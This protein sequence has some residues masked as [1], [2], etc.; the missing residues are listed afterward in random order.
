MGKRSAA[1]AVILALAFNLSA[2]A[3]SP[4][5]QPEV[6]KQDLE[7]SPVPADTLVVP[8]GFQMVD[9][10]VYVPCSRYTDSLAGRNIFHIMPYGVR[11]T[12]SPELYSASKKYIEENEQNALESEGYRIRIYFDNRQDA[13][14]ASERA[15]K[16]FEKLFPAY[17]TYRSYIYPNFK[18][19]VG[20]FRSKTDAQIALKEISR[21]FPSAFIVKERM[22]FPQI[23]LTERYTVDTISISVPLK[24]TIEVDDKWLSKD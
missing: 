4:E 22:K 18:V 23:S 6:V 19:T 5:T 24:D 2:K 14:E 21:Y 8:E 12:Q 10:L 1:A 15:Q 7:E 3:Q 20:D 16:R 13:R 9:S 11:L 17:Q